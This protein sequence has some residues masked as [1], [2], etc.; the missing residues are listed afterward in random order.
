MGSLVRSPTDHPLV[1]HTTPERSEFGRGIYQLVHFSVGVA[2]SRMSTECA[3]RAPGSVLGRV[4][5][6]N[7]WKRGAFAGNVRD[8]GGEGGGEMST[9][10]GGGMGD[11]RT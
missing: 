8:G 1:H 2:F 3:V 9:N 10:V 7:E 6:F 5:M 11:V 4:C